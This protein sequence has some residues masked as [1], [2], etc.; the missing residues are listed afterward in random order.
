MGNRYEGTVQ[1]QGSKIKIS[2]FYQIAII[3]WWR[4]FGLFDRGEY[5]S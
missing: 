4:T 3:S 2:H 5:S 1:T